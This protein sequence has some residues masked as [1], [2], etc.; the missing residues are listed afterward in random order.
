MRAGWRGLAVAAV[1]A[2]VATV[3]LYLVVIDAQGD[4]VTDG[5]TVGWAAAMALPG[6]LGVVA[7]VA[8]PQLARWL[9]FAGAV[10]A[11]VIGVL[12][13][14]SIGLLLLGVAT[15]CVLAATLCLAAREGE[16]AAR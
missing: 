12:A 11:T 7:L 2:D 8:P 14:F 3:V 10:P 1:V 5:R 6:L 16:V 4:A 15:L 13:I 9:L